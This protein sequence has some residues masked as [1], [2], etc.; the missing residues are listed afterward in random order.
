MQ[1][2]STRQDLLAVYTAAAAARVGSVAIIEG[3]IGAAVEMTN[4]AYVDSGVPVVITI[5]AIR[6]VSSRGQ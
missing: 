3:Q 2:G 5:V 1:N 4:K 6:Q